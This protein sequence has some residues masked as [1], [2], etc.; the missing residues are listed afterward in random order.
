MIRNH[1][2]RANCRAHKERLTL[3]CMCMG[4]VVQFGQHLYNVQFG[5][6]LHTFSYT[7]IWDYVCHWNMTRLPLSQAPR[8]RKQ[9]QPTLEQV[10]RVS[11]TQSSNQSSTTQAISGANNHTLNIHLDSPTLQFQAGSF[12]H[13][14]W[15]SIHDPQYIMGVM[16]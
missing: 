9:L 7:N 4:N 8:K 16:P 12:I 10:V 1:I 15:A 13:D 2:P 11:F 14:P 5:P 6:T 3:P